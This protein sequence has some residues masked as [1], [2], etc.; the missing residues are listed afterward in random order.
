[1]L[2][3]HVLNWLPLAILIGTMTAAKLRAWVMQRRG[4]RV[5]IVDWQRPRTQLLYDVLIIAVFLLWIYLLIAEAWPLSIAWLPEW[6][7]RKI[8]EALPIRLVGALMLLAAPVLFA[9]ALRSFADS[10]RIGIDREQPGPLVTGGAFAWNRNPIYTA[11]DLIIIGAFLVHGRGVFLLLGIS[12]VLL[13][14]GIVLREERF[15]QKQ[16]GAPFDGY[17]RR[18][19]RY[20]LL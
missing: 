10:W 13:V 5:I 9:A 16:Y 15:L 1:M 3:E 8:I 6:L 4:K 18:V 11:F 2:F 19:R 14:H 17:C 20:G 7:T 12:L